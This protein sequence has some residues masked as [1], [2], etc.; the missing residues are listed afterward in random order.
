MLTQDSG[1]LCCENLKYLKIVNIIKRVHFFRKI[2]IHEIG[3]ANARYKKNTQP[4]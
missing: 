1:K 2:I 3:E 4:D